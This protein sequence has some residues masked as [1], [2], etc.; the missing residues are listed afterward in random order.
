MTFIFNLVEYSC[1]DTQGADTVLNALNTAARYQ[2]DNSIT[3]V[4]TYH[5][6]RPSMEEP[7][8]LRF[9][10]FYTSEKAFW[11]HGMEP[12][13]SKA[14]MLTFD[15][16]IRK[17]FVWW[18]LYSNDIDT[19]VRETV[20][21][22][23]G[24]EVSPVQE[25]VYLEFNSKFNLEP[26]LFV[27]KFSKNQENL[28]TFLEQNEGLFSEAALY[29]F[30]FNDPIG[31]SHIIS[32]WPSQEDVINSLGQLDLPNMELRP[33]IYLGKKSPKSPLKNIFEPWN[34]EFLA[35]PESGYCLHPQ[36]YQNENE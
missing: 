11:E 4:L 22:L 23:N 17:S 31:D 26:V 13:V 2:I 12:D 20:A 10:E 29:H 7:E 1:F 32:L 3:G 24:I 28:E 15:P 34:P 5:F 8:K 18:A 33:Q 30:S 16:N 36:Y 9:I 19:K 6:S 21:T 35:E 14:L 25:H 27:A